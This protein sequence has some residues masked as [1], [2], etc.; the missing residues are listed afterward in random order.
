MFDWDEKPELNITP[1]VDVM[2][3]LLAILMV[4]TPAI[5][6]QEDINLP[7][8]S[9]TK[10]YKKQKSIQ[11]KINKNRVISIGNQH[12]TYKNFADSFIMYSQPFSKDMPIYISADKSLSYGDVMYILKTIKEAGFSK[13]SLITNG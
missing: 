6:Y 9:K 13:V 10:N 11:I 4:A 1:L 8:G 3:V 5:V 2:L 12:F 7:Q